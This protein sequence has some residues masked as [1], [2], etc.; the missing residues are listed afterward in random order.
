MG[1]QSGER[2]LVAER[3]RQLGVLGQLAEGAQ[4]AVRQRPEQVGD[5]RE[6]AGLAVLLLD[7]LPGVLAGLA[8]FGVLGV[9][10]RRVL[11]TS[12]NLVKEFGRS[13]RMPVD[14]AGQLGARSARWFAQMVLADSPRTGGARTVITS[15]EN[16]SPSLTVSDRPVTRH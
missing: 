12:S 6:V 7:A 15:C 3:R 5:G 1:G 4:L 8:V 13:A 14:W 2:R 9:L 10:G 16:H 11:S